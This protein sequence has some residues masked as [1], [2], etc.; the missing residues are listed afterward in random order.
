MRHPVLH[1]IVVWS[2]TLN[3]LIKTSAWRAKGLL[4]SSSDNIM[5]EL[6]V[7]SGSIVLI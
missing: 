7:R 2:M 5:I 4:G 6:N 1:L 3:R